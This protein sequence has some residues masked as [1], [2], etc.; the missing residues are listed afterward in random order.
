MILISLTQACTS[1][2]EVAA[3]LG[4]KYLVPK[5]DKVIANPVYKVGNKYNIKGKYY[6][7]KKDLAAGKSVFVST[8]IHGYPLSSLN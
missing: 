7:P 2:I 6:F 4:K 1:G 5:D 8:L 3:N